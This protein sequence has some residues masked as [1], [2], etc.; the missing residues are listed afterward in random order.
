MQ[1][2]L[3]EENGANSN[4]SHVVYIEVKTDCFSVLHNFKRRW[5]VRRGHLMEIFVNLPPSPLKKTKAGIKIDP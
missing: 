5:K 3:V 1:S 2:V 4:Y